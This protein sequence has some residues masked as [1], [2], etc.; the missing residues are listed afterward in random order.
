VDNEGD[1]RARDRSLF[2]GRS[3]NAR[4]SEAIYFHILNCGLRLAPAAGSGSGTND[5]PA[6]TNRVYVY[7]QDGFTEESWWE[8]LAAGRVFVTNGPLLRPRVAGHPPGNVFQLA[9]GER[10]S[11][12]IALD[13][14]TRTPVEYLEIIKNGEVAAAVRLTDWVDKQ[15]R[16]PPVDFDD[17]GWFL[18]R[19]V[20]KDEQRHQFAMSGP[21]YVERGGRPRVSRRSVQFFLDW[22]AELEKRAQAT[23]TVD[24]AARDA[25][26]A[27]QA[28]AREYFQG[29]L[30]RANA[31]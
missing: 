19:A 29:L 1:G 28:V 17:S 23:S 20:T 5:S 4:W 16:L 18:V 12:E 6:G 13:L 2:P 30:S 26:L 27:E 22:L 8:G 31:D 24:E 11:F 21:Y 7:C 10:A 3:G 15:G 14:G 9:A 25:M